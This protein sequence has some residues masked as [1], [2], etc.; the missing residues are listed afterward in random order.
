MRY[1]SPLEREVKDLDE[2]INFQNQDDLD[3]PSD[4]GKEANNDLGDEVGDEGEN[5]AEEGAD[6]ATNLSEEGADLDFD[7][8]ADDKQHRCASTEDEL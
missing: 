4:L 1:A 5:G 7:G 8:D 2:N 6:E 3:A